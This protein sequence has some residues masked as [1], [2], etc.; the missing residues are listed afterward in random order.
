MLARYDTNK[1]NQI[2]YSEFLRV[3]ARGLAYTAAGCV[4]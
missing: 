1:D 4:W 2:D 3:G